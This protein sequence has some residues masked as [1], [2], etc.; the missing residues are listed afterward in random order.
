MWLVW[1]SLQESLRAFRDGGSVRGS[2]RIG[3]GGGF[4]PRE[5]AT[6]GGGWGG[7]P[8]SMEGISSGL[9]IQPWLPSGLCQAGQEPGVG[10]LSFLMSWP[11]LYGGLGLKSSSCKW[12]E[13]PRAPAQPGVMRACTLGGS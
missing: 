12:F 6:E 5:G 13:C 8:R 3:P 4:S 9:G 10:L 7:P 2:K 1:P 11:H